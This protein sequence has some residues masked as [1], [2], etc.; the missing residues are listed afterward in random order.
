MIVSR[1]SIA[2]IIWLIN[3]QFYLMGQVGGGEPIFVRPD[4]ALTKDIHVNELEQVFEI[5]VTGT[6]PV[7]SFAPLEADLPSGH[8]QLSLDYFSPMFL[9]EFELLFERDGKLISSVHSEL[10]IMEGWSLNSI[11]LTDACKNW[12]KRGDVLKFRLG[13]TVGYRMQLRNIRF[14][15]ANEFERNKMAT[16][17]E[18]E[19]Q[20]QKELIA[21]QAYLK[22]PSTDSIKQ[23]IVSTDKIKISGFLSKKGQ[24]FLAQVPLHVRT[25]MELYDHQLVKIPGAG[26]FNIT[27]NRYSDSVNGGNDGLYSKWV[28]VEKKQRKIIAR[29]T[30]HYADQI[31]PL[32]DLPEELPVNKKGLGDF[33]AANP[34]MIKD[35]DSLGVASVTVNIWTRGLFLA[36]PSDTSMAFEYNGRKYFVDK[37]WVEKMDR[38]MIEAAD[39]KI[40]VSAILLI[41]QAFLFTDTAIGKRIAHPDCDPAGVYCMPHNYS[42]VGMQYYGAA[43]EFLVSRYSRPDK[44]YG[45]I[46]HWIA[47]NE[48]DAGWTWTNMG[49]KDVLLFMD[50]YHTSLRL[51]HLTAKKFN[52]H[53]TVMIS[54]THNWNWVP[55]KRRFYKPKEMLEILLRYSAV[56]GDFDWGVAYH[57]FPQSLFEPRTWLDD[58]TDFTLDSKMITF[59]NI[60]VINAWVNQPFTFF[61]GKKQRLLYFSE[62]GPNSRDYTEPALLDQAASLAYVWKKMKNLDAIKVFHYQSWRDYRFDGGLRLGLR[63]YPDDEYEPLGRKPVWHVFQCMGTDKE[64]KCFEFAKS[65]IG[66]RDWSEINYSN[67][68][69]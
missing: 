28:I 42:A 57:P 16:R 63:R 48:V 21:L 55:D 68:I 64:D 60:E 34:E 69:R 58:R 12:G 31:V 10:S 26:A 32:N 46:H 27:V 54:L 1:K 30:A 66:I 25:H 17:K 56:E 38:T 4:L 53:S 9:D 44:K 52:S 8:N 13:R 24:F 6:Q 50:A 59:R 39:R 47:Q 67:E 7:L 35:L 23:V 61:R 65:I 18:K 5:A 19:Q 45:R 29:S 15:E 41:D 40:I 62:Q 22:F 49:E 20:D 14:R 37:R 43:I 33:N 3:V 11:D 2:L 36:G 51:L